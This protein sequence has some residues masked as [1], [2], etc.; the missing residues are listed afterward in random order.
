MKQKLFSKSLNV[1]ETYK[2]FLTR[3]AE[4][5]LIEI[6]D[7]IAMDSPASASAF[8]LALEKKVFSLSTMPER[9]PLIP[10]NNLL[11]TRYRH[12]IHG[13]YR[14]IFKVYDQTVTVLRV[15]HGSRLLEL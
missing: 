4:N 14:I 3:H 11:G 13:R 2:I 9:E 12:L 6:Y 8:V 10:E 1:T 5:D 7:Y 15:I